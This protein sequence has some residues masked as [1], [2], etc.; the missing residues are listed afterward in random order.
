MAQVE[1]PENLFKTIRSGSCILCSGVRFGASAGYPSWER[2]VAQMEEAVGGEDGT[3]DGLV[4]RGESLTVVGY[5]KRKLGADA[6]LELL[7]TAFGEER[8]PS[9]AHK[10]LAELPFLGVFHTGYDS[11]LAR[12]MGRETA[13][14]SYRDG[15]ALRLKRD[16]SG[17]LVQAHGAPGGAVPV[18]TQRDFR[19]YIAPNQAYRSF[20]ENLYRT[21]TFLLV[22]YSLR[23]PDFKLLMQRLFATFRESAA[24]HYALLAGV[25]P[26]EAEELYANFR[27]R[28]LPYDEGDDPVASLVEA[29]GALHTQWKNKG[30]AL[31]GPDDP[32]Q[33][34]QW[35]TQQLGAVEPRLDV[36]AAEGLQMPE[37]HLEALCEAARSVDLGSLEADTLCRLGN[38]RLLRDDLAGAMAAYEAALDKDDTLAVAH[39]NLHHALAES[40]RFDDALGHLKKAVD[41]DATLRVV[42]QRYEIQRIIGR[43]TTGTVYAAHDTEEDREVTVKV[44]RAS[45]VREFVSV[46]AW[47]DEAKKL[48]EIEH[49]NV[50]TVYDAL[51][52]GGRCILVTEALEGKSLSRLLREQ[53]GPLSPEKAALLFGQACDGLIHVH[54]RGILH[55][56]IT[57]SNLFV[58]KDGAVVLM[59]FR[60]G[61][62]NK[63]SVVIVKKGSEGFQAPEL[64]AG[65]GGDARAD[66]YSLGA[67]L[68]NTLTG[69]VPLGSFLPVGELAPAA[70]RFESL[71][72]RS[73]RPV[74][75]DRPQDVAA[76]K[77]SLEGGALEVQL[78]DSEDDLEGWLGVI[79]AQPDN[80]RA[81]E[82]LG[83]LEARYRS[84]KEWEP[85]LLLLVGR[86][87]VEV[88]ATA[89]ARMLREASRVF[90]GEMED[91]GSAF[92]TL[93]E[94]FREDHG[95][96][97]VRKDLERL[98]KAT[99]LWNDLLQEYN[100]LVQTLQDP[101]LSC[102][103]LVRMGRIYAHELAYDDYAVTTFQQA[104]AVDGARID[105]LGELAE[106]LDRKGEHKERA[107]IL[108]RLADRE[109][110]RVR[111]VEALRDLAQLY[112]RELGDHEQAMG[113][114]R[115]V[116]DLD[117][118][119]TQALA[120]LR[121]LYRGQEMW[122]ELVALLE[123]RVELTEV[124]EDLAGFR[125]GLA[126]VYEEGL[127]R[128]EKA[129]EQYQLL[130]EANPNDDKAL[131]GLERLYDATGQGDKYL[132]ILDKRIASAS[133][134]D[135]VDL[136]RRMA[137]QWGEQEGGQARAAEYL[138]MLLGVRPA[139]AEALKGLVKMY[140]AIPDHEKLADA[141]QRSIEA[142]RRGDEKSG[143][144]AGLG[145][146]YEEH[147]GDLESAEKT[148]GRLLEV[149]PKNK[150]GL[151]SLARIHEK[152]EAWDKAVE[153]LHR[154][155]PVEES[156]N[157][158]ADLFARIGKIQHEK[159]GKV[160]EA[161][162]NLVKARELRDDH[163]DAMVQLASL[164]RDRKDFGKAARMLRE[165]ARAMP[166]ELEK[167]QRLFQS[168]VTYLDDIEDEA[169]A[170]E[171]FEELLAMDPEHV[172][173]GKRLAPIYERR[174][175]REKAESLLEMLVR[176][177]DGKDRAGLIELN[178]RLGL[179]AKENGHEDRAS[180]A[181]RGAYD[182]DPTNQMSLQHLAEML[183]QK[184]ERAESAKLFQALLVHRRDSMTPEETVHVFHR[185]G[186]IKQSQGENNKALNML[187]KALAL[188]PSHREVLT[189]AAELYQEKK[190]LEAVL[191]CKKALLEGCEDT[192]EKG[193]LAEEVGDLLHQQL[194]RD[195][196]A[197]AFYKQVA[198]GTPSHRRVLNKI[199]EIYIEG[200][201]WEDAISAMGKIEDHE[202]EPL[203]RSRLHYTAGVIFRDELNRPE[204]AAHH[205]DQA[206]MKDPTFRKA[207]DATK[208]LYTQQKNW[209]AL[210]NA[211]E[212]MLERLP[213]ETPAHEHG[214]LWQELAVL[215]RDKLGDHKHAILAFEKASKLEP[216]DGQRKA[217]L[218]RLYMASGPDAYDKAVASYQDLLRRDP[219]SMEAYRQLRRLYADMKQR[220]R[221]WCVA[222][223]LSTLGAGS[224]EDRK[225]YAEYRQSKPRRLER[226]LSDDLWEAFLYHGSQARTLSRTFA[227]LSPLVIPMT[228]R[229]A[230]SAGLGAREKLDLAGDSRPFA[231]V[232]RTMA[233]L[234]DRSPADA[235]IQANLEQPVA[236]SVVGNRD[237]P[238][239][240]LRF[241]PRV[242]KT[243]G[244]TELHYWLA[245]GY[246]GL[247]KEHLVAAAVASPEVLRAVVLAALKVADPG[248][249][250]AGD[251][252]PLEKMA[253]LFRRQLAPAA[254]DFLVSEAKGLRES[255]ELETLTAWLTGVDHSL[256]RAAL[257]VC[258]DLET[259]AKLLTTEPD[260]RD[261]GVKVR[262]AELFAFAASE[263]YFKLR[264]LLQLTVGFRPRSAAGGGSV[265]SVPRG[266]EHLFVFV[267]HQLL[268]G[269]PGRAEVLARVELARILGEHLA[270]QRGDG[271]A[272]VGVDVDLAHGRG[273]RPAELRLAHA[274]RALPLASIGVDHLH[275]LREHRGGAVQHDR[276]AR[277]PPG[278]LVED[279][280]PQGRG[281]L[282]RLHL[283]LVGPMAGADADGQA[284]HARAR[285]KVLH[286]LRLG[287]AGRLV[288]HLV[289]DA[290]QHA[291]LALHRHVVLVGVGRH[292]L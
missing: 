79:G 259:A 233:Q 106:V 101:K 113:A 256:T 236:V 287:V 183:Y 210:A 225:F 221:A 66:I 182:L 123:S 248:L 126:E 108:T 95:N 265:G 201:R 278:H 244:E 275:K 81:L 288:L 164:Y 150:I 206:L 229:D 286:L 269:L 230:A 17:F 21:R 261:V 64:L 232:A 110:D 283:E 77:K 171:V 82:V 5:L 155:V 231:R 71:V 280:E 166:N 270:D 40:K 117:P 58:K 65:A 185:L 191:R 4:D 148:F 31:P 2:L 173:S 73:L 193:D 174:G 90:E 249:R 115:K 134:D 51:M 25:T 60:G 129:I 42:P 47:L 137:A 12:A 224:E 36:M 260:P 184:G 16:L 48:T 94:A 9:E 139:D 241:S 273:G 262:V 62:A 59:D 132:E 254:L 105:A 67:V 168:A 264:E 250:L 156:V 50:V 37:S 116:L 197:V 69:K 135:K 112:L 30:E 136:C 140:W 160:D 196:E 290:R 272:S 10:L 34:A 252:A 84:E 219:M 149:A 167:V 24:D 43:G 8:D 70:R 291:Q 243:T 222:A 97:E 176:K 72:T 211:Y 214:A 80:D 255:S 172:A 68:Y 192:E 33:K 238:R 247:R 91:P 165:A 54:A 258:D 52:E 127:G 202:T 153:V 246:F 282:S 93:R 215:Y 76:F 141:Y 226:K 100:T 56:D 227:V 161:E 111:K 124:A 147:L 144:L 199:M 145:M 1:F 209:A 163:V 179:V 186:E 44:M 277:E 285:D 218:A 133:D 41:N 223:V 267:Y 157:A 32:E 75:E 279:V 131:R 195:D 189:R 57:P 118:D 281:L 35:L 99:G 103:W 146:V 7:T 26:P 19:R 292:L 190:D 102:D 122:D 45:Y 22:G 92:A 46:D 85:L 15:A 169:R 104:L 216:G 212:V 268:E 55:L 263:P 200:R 88:D 27:V 242:V 239:T 178:T 138:E 86:A 251:V 83:K 96:L 228:A 152:R 158:Q 284:V 203:H 170:V 159:M 181:F 18:M 213:A 74:P 13:L 276:E 11:A 188:A 207:F 208:K 61:R 120:A 234:S 205:F 39:L 240:V 23:D 63:G 194:G 107:K 109:E 198:E 130:L 78:P 204:D 38:A 162:T 266:P 121:G 142:A 87:E 49:D 151:A 28:V 180:A 271:Q 20:V 89:R 220:D 53:Q 253:T 274:H 143:L 257:V 289:L 29:V 175:E 14:F 125:H 3:L 119:N 237:D 235:Y 154:L 98:A 217:D 187:E 6:T 245:K 128:K 177:D 114:Y